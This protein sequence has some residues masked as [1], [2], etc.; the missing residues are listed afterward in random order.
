MNRLSLAARNTN[1]Q[2]IQPGQPGIVLWPRH[3]QRPNPLGRVRVQT[4]SAAA[5]RI[6]ESRSATISTLAGATQ[7]VER[8]PGL[9]RATR[10]ALSLS[11]TGC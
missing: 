8:A 5:R 3:R 4:R 6:V 9:L 11:G 7:L 2:V 1:K 10:P